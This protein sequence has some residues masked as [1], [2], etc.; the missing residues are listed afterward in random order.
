MAYLYVSPEFICHSILDPRR[1]RRY[2]HAFP[3]PYPNIPEVS[4]DQWRSGEYED[5]LEWPLDEWRV[6]FGCRE[7]GYVATYDADA[8][9]ETILERNNQANFHNETNCYSVQLQCAKIDC[10]APAKLHV[11][12]KDGEGAKELLRLLKESFFDGALPCAIR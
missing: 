7:C 1:P 12:L 9:G 6:L 5:R 11:N 8:L 2:F 3:I 4:E 10:K